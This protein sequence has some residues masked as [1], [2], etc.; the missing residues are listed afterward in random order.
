MQF[1]IMFHFCMT[2]LFLFFLSSHSTFFYT[3][4]CFHS[5]FP[6]ENLFSIN[7]LICSFGIVLHI[8]NWYFLK[9]R[10]LNNV[11]KELFLFTFLKKIYSFIW[12]TETEKGE[13][14]RK[15]ER[16]SRRLHAEPRA[17]HWAW[18]QDPKITTQVKT[19]SQ[20]L[21]QSHPGTL[22]LKKKNL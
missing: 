19:K 15:K 13:G 10:K 9:G 5:A 11:L 1:Y 2:P 21:N 20:M 17:R 22:I 14:Q 3:T 7:L 12:E 18:S 4:H 6:N 8:D 16:I